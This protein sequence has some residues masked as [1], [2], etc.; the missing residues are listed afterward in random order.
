MTQHFTIT[1]MLTFYL[2]FI[3]CLGFKTQWEKSTSTTE[4]YTLQCTKPTDRKA[5]LC[6]AILY[7]YQ[8]NSLRFHQVLAGYS[9]VISWVDSDAMESLK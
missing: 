7:I 6:C 3:L 9:E 2:S 8:I 5:K 1:T 4:D